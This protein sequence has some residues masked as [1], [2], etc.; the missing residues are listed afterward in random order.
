MADNTKSIIRRTRRPILVGWAMAFVLVAG[1][2][3][4]S[5]LGSS[6]NPQSG[7]T[8]VQ[9][10]ISS[11]P[12][13]TAPTIGLPS[14]GQVFTSIPITVSGLCSGNLLVKV[15]ANGVFVGSAVCQHGS[16]SLKIDLFS[17]RNDLVV[18]Q[19]DALDQTSPASG[20]TTVTFNDTS[21]VSFGSHV[22]LTSDYARRGANPGQTLTWPVTVSDGT[23]PYALSV[24]W[25]DGKPA[26]LVS[27]PYPGT[28]NLQH[29]Y[30]T[31]GT[32]NI[33]VKATDKNGSTAYLQLVGVANGAVGSQNSGSTANNNNSTSKQTAT[34]ILWWPSVISIVLL[35]PGFWLGRRY[36]L[37][38]IRKKVESGYR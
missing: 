20:T 6:Q 28:V 24:D 34:K 35:I 36:E 29:V 15:F 12:P 3:N 1:V 23:G 22:A 19:Y 37:A 32:Y 7:S 13:S 8:G 26:D 30:D 18:R 11:P 38:A 10:E 33:V 2:G 25:G 9:A 16:Y 14:N 17:G 27:Q 5:A 4:V 31:A 21:F